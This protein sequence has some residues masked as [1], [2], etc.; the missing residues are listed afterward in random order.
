MTTIIIGGGIAG[1]SAAY[2]LDDNAIIFERDDCT[3]GL[4]SSY[5]VNGHYIE[6]YYHHFFEGDRALQELCDSLG[7]GLEWHNGTVGYS[8]NGRI[9][10]MN[11]AF[12]ILAYPYMN[13]IEKFRLGLFT[14]KCK[15]EDPLEHVDETAVDYIK[16]NVGDSVYRKFFLPL[17]K[18]KFGD[19]YHDVSAAWLI[20]RIKL[21][22]NRGLKGE[23]LG[24]VE[25]GFQKL[26]DGMANVVEKKGGTIRLNTPVEDIVVED[27]TAR[28]VK[29]AE[30]IVRADRVI[31]TSP[32]LMLKYADPRGIYFQKTVC[33]LFSLKKKLSDTYWVNIGDDLSFKALIEHTNL[34]PYERYGEHLL[35]AVV[36]SSHPI[37]PDRTLASFKED[38][39][40]YGIEEGDIN[41]HRTYYE[42][43]TAPMYNRSYRYVP[44]ESNIKGLYFAGLFSRPNHSGRLVNGSILAGK[45]VA[46]ILN[47]KVIA[48]QPSPITG[49]SA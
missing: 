23:K 12:E 16:R 3:G 37:D 24:Y 14:L 27:G 21:R 34:I 5:R 18:G 15:R 10:P 41:W 17:L 13:L 1:L 4:C 8:F 38:L 48:S 26:V 28:G 39:K 9:Y 42:T 49:D 32:A 2:H 36:Y 19:D 33:T 11:K 7:V 30:G 22:S 31:C 6:K 40:K 20:V 35:Y 44:Y 43:A 46:D 25:G 29:T 45:E 47:K